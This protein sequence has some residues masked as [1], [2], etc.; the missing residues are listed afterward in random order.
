MREG[1]VSFYLIA[2]GKCYKTG[3]RPVPG[4]PAVPTKPSEASRSTRAGCA[5]ALDALVSSTHS[6]TFSPHTSA[7]QRGQ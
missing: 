4:L 7:G 3:T 1:N 6:L 5:D 2:L